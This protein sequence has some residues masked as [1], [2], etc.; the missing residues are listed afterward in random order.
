MRVF[1]IWRAEMGCSVLVEESAMKSLVIALEIEEGDLIG[2]GWESGTTVLSN[3]ISHTLSM[4]M[5]QR[6][7]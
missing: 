2:H 4:Y 7:T 1:E 5:F 3:S 6:L